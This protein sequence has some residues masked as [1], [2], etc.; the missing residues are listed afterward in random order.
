M[1]TTRIRKIKNSMDAASDEAS[2]KADTVQ[3]D[4][5]RVSVPDPDIA[6]TYVPR[7]IAGKT[8]E[9]IFDVAMDQGINVLLEGPTGSG[10]TRA[11]IS[12]AAKRQL[13]FYNVPSNDGIE[14]SQIFGKYVPDE[15]NPGA[16]VW[17]DGPAVTVIRNGGVLLLNEV[18]FIPPR[19][20]TVLF[21]VLDHR[22]EVVLMDH[23]GEII[24]AH[25]RLLVVAD[26]NPDY[27]GTRMMNAAFRNRFGLQLV[28]PYSDDVENKLVPWDSLRTLANQLRQQMKAGTVETP[29]GT[30]ML[31]EFISV[32]Y[33]LGYDL[34]KLSF[35]NHFSE[36]ERGAVDNVLKTHE[37][38]L[39][40]DMAKHKPRSPNEWTFANEHDG[41][42]YNQGNKN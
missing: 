17:E 12:Y 29:V 36:E 11:V 7:V 5:M 8:E 39:M 38:G 9:E 22:R 37:T 32:S 28:W 2:D 42:L 6:K 26:M 15:S 27:A 33:R 4:V 23:H 25:P 16:L 1:T 14:P 40:A 35:V 30:N 21:G 18:N 41:W 10:K 3:D 20:S 34:A 31:V 24:K 13:P 19:I